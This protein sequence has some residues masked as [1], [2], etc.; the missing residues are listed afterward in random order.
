MD[1][2]FKK[3]TSLFSRYLIILILGVGDLYLI[4]KILTPLTLHATNLILKIFTPTTLSGNTIYFNQSIIQIVPA[5]VAGSAFYLLI[6]LIL[7]TAN[8]AP[9]VR[10]KALLAALTAF[11]AL[12]ITRI[13]ILITLIK[14]PEFETIHFIFWHIVST[15]FV[16]ATYIATIKLYKIKSVPIIS[17][18]NYLKSLMRPKRKFRKT[19]K[20]I[21]AMQKN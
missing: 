17:D 1:K 4:Y 6:A 3:I 16:I 15:I 20:N 12:N 18:F 5:C 13:L 9:E 14:T 11:F 7:S 19:K 21:S 2:D 8:I 10:L